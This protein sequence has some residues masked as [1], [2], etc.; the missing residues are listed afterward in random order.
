[1][2]D[3]T[4]QRCRV[5]AAVCSD[6]SDEELRK[7]QQLLWPEN[8]TPNV[9]KNQHTVRYRT[10]SIVRS[11]TRISRSTPGIYEQGTAVVV[12]QLRA[13]VIG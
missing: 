11:E 3:T 1:M 4:F 13:V 2:G 12:R 5:L 8:A 10:T 6:P 7:S 9:D